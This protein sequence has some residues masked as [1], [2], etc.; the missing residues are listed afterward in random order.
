MAETPGARLARQAY[1]LTSDLMTPNPAIYW[2]DLLA[3]VGVTYG[4]LALSVRAETPAAA[5]AW[6]VV[7]L[8]GA[9]RAISFIH[10]LTHL[11]GSD[12]PGFRLGWNLLIGIPAL[13]PSFLY[14]GVHNLHHAKDRYGTPADPE[15]LPLARGPRGRIVGFIV[16]SLLA[17]VGVAIRFGVI[18]PVS[19]LVPAIRRWARRRVS[20]LTINPDFV[21]EDMATRPAWLFQEIACWL[22]CWAVAA[23]AVAGVIPLRVI[24]T[25]AWVMAGAAFLNQLRTLCAHHWENEGEPMS[26]EAQFLD[27]IN[28]PP[29]GIW[30]ALWAPVGLRYHALHHLLPRLPYHNLAAAHRRLAKGLPQASAYHRASRRGLVPGIAALLRGAGAQKA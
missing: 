19:L 30:P 8:L 4:S 1:D 15:Y 21:R 5:L 29:P 28:V 12:A 11:R 14:E 27:S 23:G 17:P 6:A 16:L 2:L 7:C 26:F 25:A 22:W 3:T 9:Y 10:E 18:T 13:A 24:L 20:A